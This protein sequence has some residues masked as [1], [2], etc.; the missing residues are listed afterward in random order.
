M[1]KNSPLS[2]IVGRAYHD[3]AIRRKD[4]LL[5]DARERIAALNKSE[6]DLLERAQKA[7]RELD[8][9]RADNVAI[10]GA[11]EEWGR[12]PDLPRVPYGAELVDAETGETRTLELHAYQITNLSRAIMVQ[13]Q[14]MRESEW[15][16]NAIK[17][18]Y[19]HDGLVQAQRS[20]YER[21]M[22]ARR[23]YDN[24]GNAAAMDRLLAGND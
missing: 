5:A 19:A 6:G 17:S 21:I 14:K 13:V 24:G 20:A 9:A 2:Q 15:G 22:R 1:P 23:A 4:E 11:L 16:M 12:W 18:H 7:E 8:W 3:E 10:L